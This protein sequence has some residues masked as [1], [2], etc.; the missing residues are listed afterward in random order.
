MLLR[1]VLRTR[2]LFLALLI[3]TAVSQL[4]A[5]NSVTVS[6]DKN[7]VLVRTPRD[8]LHIAV[9]GPS[10]LHITG[11]VDSPKPSSAHQP[12]I[13][14]SCE[15]GQFS[16]E[17]SDKVATLM[18]PDLRVKIALDS[19]GLAVADKAG[20][21]LLTEGVWNPAS[22]R[23]YDP[24]GAAGDHLYRVTETFQIAED[25]AIYGLGQHQSGLL[26][27]RDIAVSLAQNNTDVAVPLLVSTRGYGLL[28]N[29]AARSMMDN[30]FHRSIRW[31]AD[32]TEGLDYYFLYGPEIDQIVHLYREL[33]GHA[34][35][36]GEWAYGFFQSK[37]RYLSQDELVGIVSKYRVEHIPLDTVVQDWQWW[38]KWGSSEFNAEFPDFASAVDAAATD[39]AARLQTRSQRVTTHWLTPATPA[40]SL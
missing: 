26:N 17:Q 2:L 36:F 10:I 19:G 8:Q 40:A 30:Q 22:A 20:N 23:R 34:P 24:F 28:W 35:L 16:L 11:G 38:T 25:E 9:C 15:Q 12:W 18:T 21:P 5:Q 27:Y 14:K 7:G 31:T 32:G 39:L 37:D 4:P 6:Q 33:T 13:V 29:T 1:Y 3:S